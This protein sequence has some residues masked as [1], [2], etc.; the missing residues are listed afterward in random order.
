METYSL[1]NKAAKAMK[2]NI[3]HTDWKERNLYLK[4]ANSSKKKKKVHQA[5][6]VQENVT[7]LSCMSIY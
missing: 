7:N 6:N 3:M 4:Q 1:Q 5:A 2:G